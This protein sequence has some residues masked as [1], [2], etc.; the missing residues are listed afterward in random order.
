VRQDL[1]RNWGFQDAIQLF[2]GPALLVKNDSKV[3]DSGIYNEITLSVVVQTGPDKWDLFV[4][5]P[6]RSSPTTITLSEVTALYDVASYLCMYDLLQ[7][8]TCDDLYKKVAEVHGN[9][10]PLYVKDPIGDVLPEGK[11]TLK[12]S[13][14]DGARLTAEYRQKWS[15]IILNQGAKSTLTVEVSA[16]SFLQVTIFILECKFIV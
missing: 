15:L 16:V 2:K 9:G 12:E 10:R 6:G 7:T 3:R 11:V 13:L 14:L 8:A 5:L 4:T 1:R